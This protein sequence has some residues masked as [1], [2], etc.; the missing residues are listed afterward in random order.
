MPLQKSILAATSSEKSILGLT[1]EKKIHEV[2]KKVALTNLQVLL[3]LRPLPP[4]P[5]FWSWVPWQEI[6]SP[7]QWK[8]LV[9]P[10]NGNWFS[11][12][13]ES[14][15]VFGE[16]APP[17]DHHPTHLPIARAAQCEGEEEQGKLVAVANT[18]M[19]LD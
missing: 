16:V 10:A 19:E 8:A 12:S 3:T 13:M 1:S 9:L 18:S 15:P 6:G 2:S 17:L 4:Q 5:G 7:T 14:S 11:H